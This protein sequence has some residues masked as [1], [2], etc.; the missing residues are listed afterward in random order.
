MCTRDPFFTISQLHHQNCSARGKNKGLWLVCFLI[1]NGCL[2]WSEHTEHYKVKSKTATG[3][4]T[5]AS[6]WCSCTYVQSSY[7][8]NREELKV[9][10]GRGLGV[11]LTVL[12][13]VQ[14]VSHTDT[15]PTLNQTNAAAVTTNERGQQPEVQ[16]TSRAGSSACFTNRST[17]KQ[18]HF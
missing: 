17:E 2:D 5:R 18:R 3:L 1:F 12:W 15:E 8:D 10:G 7:S 4:A 11:S 14:F 13:S 16:R 9:G 6:K